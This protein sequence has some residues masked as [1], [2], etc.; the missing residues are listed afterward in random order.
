MS[1]KPDMTKL[2]LSQD[3]LKKTATSEKGCLPS[4]ADIAQ[5]KTMINICAGN[6]N[7][8]KTTVV[9]KNVLPTQADID[10]EKAE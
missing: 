4:Q 10:A 3:G 7:L 8:K 9:E 1:D 2:A 6:I 5:E